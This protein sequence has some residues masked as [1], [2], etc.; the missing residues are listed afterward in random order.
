MQSAGVQTFISRLPTE[1][2]GIKI[3]LGMAYRGFNRHCGAS[4]GNT[5]W[6]ETPISNYVTDKIYAL[7]VWGKDTLLITAHISLH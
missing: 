4:G 2:H 1:L 3:Q 7:K 5:Y 6:Y